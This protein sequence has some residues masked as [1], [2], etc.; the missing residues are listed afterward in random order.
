MAKYNSKGDQNLINNQNFL[1]EDKEKFKPV[2][3]HMDVYKEK[4]QY[5]GSIDKLKLRIVGRGDL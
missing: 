4:I 3:P 1:V 2:T 5:D